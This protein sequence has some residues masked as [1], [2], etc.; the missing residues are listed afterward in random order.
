MVPMS[1]A[2]TGGGGSLFILLVPILLL[3]FL[4]LSQRRRSQ[5][6][7]RNQQ[8]LEVGDE[9]IT[10]GGAYATIVGDEGDILLLELAPGNVVRWQRR[11]IMNSV[12]P[13]SGVD[14]ADDET[15]GE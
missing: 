2:T 9:V 15:P 13:N 10:A 8:E 14:K 6:L 12:R 1:A 3:A 7:A 4:F 5:K 11:M